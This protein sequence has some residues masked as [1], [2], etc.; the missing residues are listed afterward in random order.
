MFLWLIVMNLSDCKYILSSVQHHFVLISWK[1]YQKLA[2][3]CSYWFCHCFLFLWL[4]SI[5]QVFKYFLE[6]SVPWF[7]YFFCFHY[8]TPTRK[9]TLF[10]FHLLS[11]RNANFLCFLNTKSLLI[12]R[13][14]PFFA[15]TFFPINENWTAAVEELLWHCWCP[16]FFF[17]WTTN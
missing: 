6:I 3:K 17:N 7:Q 8:I 12:F 4:P 14:K 1:N 15:F 13:K 2:Y 11:K 9:S 5:I 10:E 16:L